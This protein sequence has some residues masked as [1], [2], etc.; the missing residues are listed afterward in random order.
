MNDHSE[1]A[2]LIFEHLLITNAPLACNSGAVLAIQLQKNSKQTVFMDYHFWG[3]FIN[4][5]YIDIKKNITVDCV[6][7]RS[8]DKKTL[9]RIELNMKAL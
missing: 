8:L 5:E 4:D 1:L 3:E 9:K 6:N 2:I 7:L